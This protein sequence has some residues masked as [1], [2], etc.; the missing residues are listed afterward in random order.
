MAL[1]T[2]VFANDGAGGPVDRSTP[3]ATVSGP[4]WTW[5]PPG[6]LAPGSDWTFLARN[7]DTATGLDDLNTDATVRVRVGP[8]GADVSARPQPVV[9][10]RATWVEPETV[11]LAWSHLA[12]G[13]GADSFAVRATPGTTPD[14]GA[15]PD[16]SMPWRKGWT[17]YAAELTGL[18]PGPYAVSVRAVRDGLDDGSG[19]FLIVSP[20]PTVPA[21]VEGL[22]ATVVGGD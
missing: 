15:A 7:H 11:R 3:V 16:L 10:L 12:S 21:A 1:Q 18:A 14:L 22:T 5:T 19:A 2:M 13:R 17:G 6:G 4:P 9:G 20:D 8:D